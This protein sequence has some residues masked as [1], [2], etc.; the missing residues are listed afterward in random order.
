VQFEW[1]PVKARK[2]FRDHRVTFEEA[3]TV[4]LDQSRITDPDIV[5]S[6]EEEYREQI[7][8]LSQKLRLLVVI[9]TERYE[10]IRLISAR[11]A[12]QAEARRYAGEV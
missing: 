1:D 9:F 8:G 3:Q 10:T 5:H 2:N 12:N 11:R 4:W 7:L 6:T